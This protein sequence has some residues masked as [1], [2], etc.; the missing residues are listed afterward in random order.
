MFCN[1]LFTFFMV[2]F[3]AKKYI[4]KKTLDCDV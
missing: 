4:Y 3:T 2:S 1:V